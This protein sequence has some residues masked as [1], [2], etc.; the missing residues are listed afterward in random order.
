[1]AFHRVHEPHL[2]H[3][4]LCRWTLRCFRIL[5]AVPSAAVNIG[6]P[7]S[8]QIRVFSDYMPRGGIAGA[9]DSSIFSFMRLLHTVF[10]CGCTDSHSRQPCSEVPFSPHP[11]QHLLSCYFLS[12]YFGRAHSMCKFLRQGWKLQCSSDLSHSRDHTRS[13]SHWATR[14]LPF[15]VFLIIA[16]LTGAVLI[17]ISLMISDVEHLFRYLLAMCMSFFWGGGWPHLWHVEV[18]GPGIKPKSQQW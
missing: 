14:E 9:C 3:P 2:L 15:L 1:M 5:P 6:L 4:L 13:L 8:F 16:I 7:V 12:F 18:P 11:C 10:L 17:C